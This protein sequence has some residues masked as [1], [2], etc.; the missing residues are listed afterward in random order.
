MCA[1]RTEMGPQLEKC[2]GGWKKN[3]SSKLSTRGPYFFGLI[4]GKFPRPEPGFKHWLR[5]FFRGKK[6]MGHTFKGEGESIAQAPGILG[7]KFRNPTTRG[8]FSGETP[9]LTNQPF[10]ILGKN[11]ELGKIVQ[12]KKHSNIPKGR[13]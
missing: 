13:G 4:P 12:P 7:P 9:G 2:L 1:P 10:I 6:K 5:G 11:P 8:F 3:T